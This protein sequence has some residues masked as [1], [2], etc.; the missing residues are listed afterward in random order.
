MLAAPRT[1]DSKSLPPLRVPTFGVWLSGFA[2]IIYHISMKFYEYVG[3]PTNPKRL[4]TKSRAYYTTV[5]LS[6]QM[7]LYIKIYTYKY[8]T[9]ILPDPHQMLQ[10]N[11]PTLNWTLVK[12]SAMPPLH[13]VGA[14]GAKTPG[15]EPTTR[16]LQLGMRLLLGCLVLN[17]C[18]CQQI[19]GQIEG[20]WPFWKIQSCWFQIITTR[21]L[22]HPDTFS[23]YMSLTVYKYTWHL[24]WASLP[25]Y[26]LSVNVV[27]GFCLSGSSR[28]STG[29]GG[30][31]FTASYGLAFSFAE[32]ETFAWS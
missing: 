22:Q 18:G 23:E 30:S 28:L 1:G 25:L 31:Q 20:P 2:Y 8:D 24:I 21:K 29:P 11:V 10:C 19:Y 9:R 32:R 14:W 6:H 27:S 15:S 12:G 7:Y 17:D 4:N 3:N 13:V 26:Q 5:S 16:N